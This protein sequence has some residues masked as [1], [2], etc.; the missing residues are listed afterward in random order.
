MSA[1]LAIP[2]VVSVVA[3]IVVDAAGVEDGKMRRKL[4][5]EAKGSQ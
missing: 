3:E 4:K 1:A 2:A 5:A